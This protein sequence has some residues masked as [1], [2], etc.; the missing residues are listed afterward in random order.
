MKPPADVVKTMLWYREYHKDGYSVAGYVNPE[1]N[2]PSCRVY[3]GSHGCSR[4][5]GHEGD[6]WCDCCECD[7]HPKQGDVHCVAGPP[8]YGDDTKFTGEDA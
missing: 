7:D 5:R 6:H 1:S 8:Y 4:S 3:W 2:F